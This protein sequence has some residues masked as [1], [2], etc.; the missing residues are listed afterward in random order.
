MLPHGETG[1]TC[2][3]RATAGNATVIYD[4]GVIA[5]AVKTFGIYLKRKTGTGTV[6]ITLDGGGSWTAVTPNG[7][8]D[9]FQITQTLADPDIGIRIVTS[10]DEVLAW[11]AQ[12]EDGRAFAT[13]LIPTSGASAQRT[14]D[15]IRIGNAA[16]IHVPAAQGTIL[17]LASPLF[18]AADIA[19]DA[20][21]LD[22]RTAADGVALRAS[23]AGDCWQAVVRS[24]GGD[25]AVLS[26][27]TLVPAKGAQHAL[28]LTW[29]VNDFRLY[30]NGAQEALDAAGAAP[31]GIASELF[32]GQ[33]KDNGSQAFAALS[34]VIAYDRVLGAQEIEMLSRAIRGEMEL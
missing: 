19:A 32:V 3:L 33:D 5:A 6:E 7:V 10:G 23:A 25:S 9:R 11:G 29:A 12:L 24:G 28:A 34:Q 13:T 20:Y 26:S 18:D 8:W 4:A 1:T 2:E 31:T 15:D 17:I 22:I 14:A 27:A 16:A 21:M 30:V